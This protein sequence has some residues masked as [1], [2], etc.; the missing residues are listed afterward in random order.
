MNGEKAEEELWHEIISSNQNIDE[1]TINKIKKVIKDITIVEEQQQIASWQESDILNFQIEK[2]KV[3]DEIAKILAVIKRAIF[4]SYDFHLRT[5]QIISTLLLYY[6]PQGRLAEI[7]TGEGKSIII[8]SFAVIKVLEGKK[9][10]ILTSSPVLAQGDLEEQNRFY[11]MFKI[12]SAENISEPNHKEKKCYQQTIVYGTIASFIGDVL[13]Q[14]NLDINVRSNRETDIIIVDEVDNM[15]IDQSSHIV[16]L[17]HPL[18]RFEYLEPLLVALW[19][20]LLQIQKQF[21]YENGKLLWT[22]YHLNNGEYEKIYECQVSNPSAFVKQQLT[23]YSNDLLKDAQP[24]IRVPTHL[25]NFTLD[26]LD[27]WANSAITAYN[28]KLDE[29]YTFIRQEDGDLDIAPIDYKNTGITQNNMHWSNGLHQFLQIKHN[30]K[31][32]PETLIINFMSNKAFFERYKGN[33]YG[34]TGTIGIKEEVNLLSNLYAVDAIKIPTF[35]HKRFNEEAPII[36]SGDSWEEIVI[37]SVISKAQNGQAVL[38]IAKTARQAAHFEELLINANYS[39]DKIR[40]YSKNDLSNK[41]GRSWQIDKNDIVISTALA[42]RGTD[43]KTTP[44]LEEE[45][46]V[47]VCI[48]YLPVNKRVLWQLYGRTSRNGNAGSAQLII[49]LDEA[50]EELQIAYPWYQNNELDNIGELF[51]WN[52]LAHKQKLLQDKVCET[53]MLSLKDY[54]FTQFNQFLSQ[55]KKP[56]MRY[57]AEVEQIRELWGIWLKDQQNLIRCN[58]QNKLDEH[59]DFSA[60]NNNIKRQALENY[61]QF[62]ATIN[63]KREHNNLITNPSFLVIRGLFNH[64]AEDLDQA[65]NLDPYF[66]FAANYAKAYTLVSNNDKEGIRQSLQ[67]ALANIEEVIIPLYQLPLHLIGARDI[68]VGESPLAVQFRDKINIMAALIENIMM[69]LNVVA[70]S[71]GEQVY[72]KIEN[73][74]SLERIFTDYDRIRDEVNEL[75]MMGITHFYEFGIYVIPKEKKGFFGNVFAIAMGLASIAIGIYLPGSTVFMQSFRAGLIVGGIKDEIISIIATAE[76][77]RIEVDEYLKGKGIELAVNVITAGIQAGLDKLEYAEALGFKSS[78]ADVGS[79]SVQESFK[80]ELIRQSQLM[81]ITTAIESTLKLGLDAHRDEIEDN[82]Q[83]AI[84]KVLIAHEAEIV[85]IIALD[86]WEESNKAKH[87]LISKGNSVISNYQGKYRQVHHQ[88]LRRVAGNIPLVS[89]PIDAYDIA[90]TLEE[91]LEITDKFCEE[92]GSKIQEVVPSDQELL[93]ASL[94]SKEHKVGFFDSNELITVITTNGLMKSQQFVHNDHQIID[95]IDLGDLTSKKETVKHA[96]NQVI[97]LEKGISR[98][99]Y[100]QDFVKIENE[101][102]VALSNQ[103]IRLV[104][105]GIFAPLAAI[106]SSYVVQKL[107]DIQATHKNDLQEKLL[108][109]RNV[110]VEVEGLPWLKSKIDYEKETKAILVDLKT[111][112]TAKVEE[113]IE[114]V[115][116]TKNEAIAN[117]ATKSVK[118]TSNMKQVAQAVSIAKKAYIEFSEKYPLLAEHGMRVL[119]IGLQSLFAGAAG[120]A[121]ALRAEGT[122][123]IINKAAGEEISYLIEAGIDK[124]SKVL[125]KQY[126][127]LTTQEARDIAGGGMFIA[128]MVKDGSGIATQVLRHTAKVRIDLL[129]KEVTNIRDSNKEVEIDFVSP[130][131]TANKPIVNEPDYNVPENIIGHEAHKVELRASME[132]PYVQDSKLNSIMSELYRDTAKVGSGSTADALRKELATGNLVGG[133]SHDI[134]TEQRI[135]NLEKWIRNNPTASPGD[136]AS[137]ENV[138]KDLQNALKR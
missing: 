53:D 103:I 42:G 97:N 13:Y 112:D 60:Y 134:K 61:Q 130:Y 137:A 51:K 94:R 34:T 110:Q 66:S 8:A 5:I 43:F 117:S 63:Y 26:Q 114:Q 49:N 40:L 131:N 23:N 33:I 100:H 89:L 91:V 17:A 101:A 107:Q 58:I 123:Y 106:S 1:L 68:S 6:A 75:E 39:K 127:E 15:F 79:K 138:L 32:S 38:L 65:K 11:R 128:S 111:E 105:S 70:Q 9:I 113:L 62:I 104:R 124:S 96:F 64:N 56:E 85:K 35:K 95:S 45:G 109:A 69:D 31:I 16:M 98:E 41:Y 52:D 135:I 36:A 92:F 125:Q 102:G 4:L 57:N 46:G 2:E 88:I 28:F 76:G 119:N 72:L 20:R 18:S 67:N 21:H 78:A 12:T 84:H 77:K 108:A 47:H 74:I 55:F 133:K 22:N 122:G 93:R 126:P 120:F 30:L 14:E 7:A 48:S 116:E 121:N 80:Q 82:I 81:L 86:R 99:E 118:T 25:W 44:E 136:R 50:I 87:L 90:K 24:I 29:D 10:D 115:K 54:L 73:A 3:R 83:E 59:A 27:D 71:Q 19:E 37:A 129:N 132:R